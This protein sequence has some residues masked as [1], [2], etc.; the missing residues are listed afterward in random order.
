MTLPHRFLAA[1]ALLLTT[2]ARSVAQAPASELTRLLERDLATYPARAGVYVKNLR[3]GEEAMVN[4]DQ[5]FNSASVIK[6]AVMVRAFQLADQ[7][8]LDLDARK[9]IRRADIRPGS[10]VFQFHT[11]GLQPTVHDLLLEMIITSDN[12]ATDM[13]VSLVGGVDS[14]NTWLK[15]SGFTNTEVIGPGYRY[16]R[17]VLAAFHPMFANLTAEETTGLEYAETDNPLFA[18]YASLFVGERA[19]WVAMMR[20]PDARKRLRALRNEITIADRAYWLGAMTP[21]ETGRLLEGIERGTL[22]SASSSERMKVL[23][24][25]QQLG[26]RRIPHFL[27]V[28]VGHKTGDSQV[29]ANDVGLVYTPKG[30]LVLSFFTNGVTGPMGE[31][32]DR[33]GRTARAIVDYFDRAVSPPSR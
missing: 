13:L 23:L 24:L 19:A 29:I 12:T 26:A 9:E 25:R 21:R 28:P 33:I 16:R 30:T 5:A 4:A 18:Q 32:E 11:P 27:S 7:G 3:T 31:A 1:F 8:T 22:A 20:D 14:L 17:R 15:A 6:L 2:A 10:G